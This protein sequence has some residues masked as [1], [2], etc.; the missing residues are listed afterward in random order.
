MRRIG[1]EA[2]RFQFGQTELP[3]LGT[4]SAFAMPRCTHRD[5][6]ARR[7]GR[8]FR[9]IRGGSALN[10]VQRPAERLWPRSG[11]TRRHP[12][13]SA[14]HEIESDEYRFDCGAAKARC[15]VCERAS[16]CRV[17]TPFS[18]RPFPGIRKAEKMSWESSTWLLKR[19]VRN[20]R[21][22]G[23][24]GLDA[25]SAEGPCTGTPRPG[26]GAAGSD[27]RHLAE[28]AIRRERSSSASPFAIR[29]IYR[30]WIQNWPLPHR[31]WKFA[32]HFESTASRN[33]G[34]GWINVHAFRPAPRNTPG[35]PREAALA[36]I[37]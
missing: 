23:R 13:D 9:L 12:V 5:G 3:R 36:T 32:F 2:A 34:K 11:R 31:L 17:R 8:S 4:D 7:H 21:G 18:R 6:S 14:G 25:K 27:G 10:A 33:A 24:A 15:D 20:V 35:K 19:Q 29:G 22:H 16:E 28:T 30:K 37:A 26:T 1:V